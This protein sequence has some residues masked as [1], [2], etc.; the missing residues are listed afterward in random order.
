MAKSSVTAPKATRDPVL[1]SMFKST[2]HSYKEG[3]Q[4]LAAKLRASFEGKTK[5]AGT[6]V[7]KEGTLETVPKSVRATAAHKRTTAKMTA[8]AAK[9]ND[10][11][12][13]KKRAKS[14]R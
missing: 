3:V 7:Y 2:G 6:V 10:K 14:A 4:F 8:K 5:P 9:K 13:P 12:S 11:A 1:A